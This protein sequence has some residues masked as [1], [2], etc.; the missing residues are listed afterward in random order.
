MQEDR[1]RVEEGSR[2][3]E[4]QVVMPHSLRDL[5]PHTAWFLSLPDTLPCRRAMLRRRARG[6]HGR[7]RL[8][9][10]GMGRNAVDFSIK[11]HGAL[12]ETKRN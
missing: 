4:K 3:G 5:L 9:R 10:A 2:G 8:K 1:K 12:R 11:P 6:V 7:Q